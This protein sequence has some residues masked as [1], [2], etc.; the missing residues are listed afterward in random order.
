MTIDIA[1]TKVAQIILYGHEIDRAERELRGF[2][3]TLNEEECYSLIAI[4]WVGRDSFGPDEYAEALET[5][6][7]EAVTPTAD[8]LIGTPH[9]ADHLETGL[10]LLGISVSDA[11]Q[12]LL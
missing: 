11:E 4:M 5:A 6:R 2:L 3:E 7:R 12:S 9:F 1:V 10:E 8:Y